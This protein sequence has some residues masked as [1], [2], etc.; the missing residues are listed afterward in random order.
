MG[1]M[2]TVERPAPTTSMP[3]IT[4][5]QP[6]ATLVAEGVKMIETRHWPAPHALIGQR[7]AIHAAKKFDREITIA[8]VGD[9]NYDRYCESGGVERCRIADMPAVGK[10][11]VALGYVPLA[12]LP[13]GS[14]IATAVLSKCERFTQDGVRKLCAV[15]G[16]DQLDYG[17]FTVG[18]YGWFFRDIQK[19]DKPIPARGAQG[20][21]TW[22]HREGA[23]E[24]A[25]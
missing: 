2:T 13:V 12:T 11:V 17:D 24:V 8:I 14:V 5:W 1:Q 23:G 21:W 25:A 20:I 6:W 15:Y 16:A 9:E 18:R 3:A 19:F 10:V 7:I 22:E 4:L